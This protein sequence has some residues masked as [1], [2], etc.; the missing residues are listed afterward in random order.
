M[1][2]FTAAIIFIIVS[3]LANSVPVS[4]QGLAAPVVSTWEAIKALPSKEE[5]TVSLI[6]GSTRKGRVSDVTD[7]ALILSQGKKLT[8][9]R[10]DVIVQIYQS[11]SRSRKVDTATG[12]LVGAGFGIAGGL[13]GDGSSGHGQS[14]GTAIGGVF[15]GAGFGA[16]VGWAIARGHERVLTYQARQ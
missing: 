8:E 9:V 6:D 13:V 4:A 5:L 3:V 1:R 15:L 16:L 11:V 7:T 2:K 10:R 14:F 12:A